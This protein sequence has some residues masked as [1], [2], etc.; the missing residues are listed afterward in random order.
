MPPGDNGVVEFLSLRLKRKEGGV[1]VI[2]C[3]HFPFHFK[4]AHYDTLIIILNHE[5]SLHGFSL[6]KKHIG[7]N[8]FP[9]FTF[10][11]LPCSPA[12]H[13]NTKNRQELSQVSHWQWQTIRSNTGDLFIWQCRKDDW[14][15]TLVKRDLIDS[16][17]DEVRFNRGHASYMTINT[18][19]KW[20]WK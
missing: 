16:T 9:D 10:V 20:S 19:W 17:T 1:V 15:W 6:W 18:K 7:T 11:A 5:H 8:W 12:P 4:C 14:R 2:C 13:K 3:F